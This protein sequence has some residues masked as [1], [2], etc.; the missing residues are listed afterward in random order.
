MFPC[1]RVSMH[2]CF[3]VFMFPCLHLSMLP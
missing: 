1:L 2:F 3:H